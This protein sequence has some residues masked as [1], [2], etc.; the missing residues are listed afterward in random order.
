MT[1]SRVAGLLPAVL[2]LVVGH[3]SPSWPQGQG[4]Q[5]PAE[6]RA[7]SEILSKY[8]EL[9]HDAPNDIQGNRI[10]AE[11]KK[12]FCAKIPTGDVSGW[13]GKVASIDDHTPDKGINLELDVQTGNLR[14]GSLGIV[15]SLGNDYAYGVQQSN[16]R[17]H[18]PTVIPAGSPLYAVTAGLRRLDVIR[19][20]ATFIPYSPPQDCY[21]NNTSY[22]S[23]IRF[24]KI[25]RIGWNINLY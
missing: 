9:Y 7:L 2:A 3:S 6:Q 21:K 17:T 22:F 15:L 10:E 12:E 8:N 4:V 14:K 13:I 20:N 19:F 11:F 18:S 24:I 1:L 25:N 23:L 5:V 16:T